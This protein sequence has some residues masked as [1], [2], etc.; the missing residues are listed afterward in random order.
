MCL[1]YKIMSFLE[2]DFCLWA[3]YCL[4]IKIKTLFIQIVEYYFGLSKKQKRK[5]NYLFIVQFSELENRAILLNISLHFYCKTLLYFSE[6]VSIH[7]LIPYVKNWYNAIVLTLGLFGRAQRPAVLFGV[8][9]VPCGPFRCFICA[10]QPFLFTS[11]R[12]SVC[13]S[14][15]CLKGFKMRARRV[16]KIVKKF[17]EGTWPFS[18]NSVHNFQRN[19]KTKKKGNCM[20]L[21]MNE[22]CFVLHFS[23]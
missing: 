3:Q 22:N 16:P 1:L 5:T 15:S 19:K 14:V 4:C 11:L 2:T 13:L 23:L 6:Y 21:K 20:S 8:L 12:P 10:R 7:F 9:Y 17:A 18:K